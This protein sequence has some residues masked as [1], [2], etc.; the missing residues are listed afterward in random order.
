M[1]SDVTLEE[2]DVLEKS[3]KQKKKNPNYNAGQ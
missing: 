2:N 1:R 3:N